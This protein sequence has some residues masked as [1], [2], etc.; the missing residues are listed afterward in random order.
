M[1]TTRY[2][3]DFQQC[4]VGFQISMTSKAKIWCVLFGIA[5]HGLEDTGMNAA[6]SK[7][8]YPL[9]GPILNPT[10][11]STV[12]IPLD[13][14]PPLLCRL[15][16]IYLRIPSESIL[17]FCYPV[18]R[19]YQ[20]CPVL[21]RTRIFDYFVWIGPSWKLDAGRIS[22]EITLYS[23]AFYVLRYWDNVMFPETNRKTRIKEDAQT[24]PQKNASGDNISCKGGLSACL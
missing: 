14:P 7:G 3:T 18:T 4:S 5:D 17:P 11:R 19:Y 22:F 6:A 24:M 13:P 20:F 12:T 10:S 1:F 2:I 9:P 15:L 16:Q 23:T 21:V 8:Q